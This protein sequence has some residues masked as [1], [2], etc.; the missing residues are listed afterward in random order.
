MDRPNPNIK[1]HG[2]RL[3]FGNQQICVET[4]LLVNEA[5]FERCSDF[6]V[7]LIKDL[8]ESPEMIVLLAA[9]FTYLTSVEVR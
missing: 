3:S 1:T 8:A 9:C 5:W 4:L 7:Q 2:L 6:A